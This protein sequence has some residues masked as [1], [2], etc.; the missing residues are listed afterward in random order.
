MKRIIAVAAF[1]MA[2]P[3]LANPFGRTDPVMPAEEVTASVAVASEEG[4]RRLERHV[5]LDG[6]C[7]DPS[8]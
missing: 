7:F 5:E 2:T 6:E 4:E 8:A 1:A 3:V